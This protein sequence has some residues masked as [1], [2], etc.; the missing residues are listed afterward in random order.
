MAPVSGWGLSF[1]MWNTLTDL[2]IV[3]LKASYEVVF[4][5]FLIFPWEIWNGLLY[6]PGAVL[7]AILY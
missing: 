3:A 1:L 5:D 4:G 2:E 7:G 6:V